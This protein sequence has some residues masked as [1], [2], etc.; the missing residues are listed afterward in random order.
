M[1]GLKWDSPQNILLSSVWSTHKYQTGA[2]YYII[3]FI[4]NSPPHG[5]DI[6]STLVH[7]KT[8]NKPGG[9][10]NELPYYIEQV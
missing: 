8:I 6:Y 4:L 3:S 2:N 7:L 5:G 10:P 1:V 9:F